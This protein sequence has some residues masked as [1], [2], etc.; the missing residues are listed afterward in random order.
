ML[1]RVLPLWSNLVQQLE[2]FVLEIQI[3]T[4]TL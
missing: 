3:A 4:G 2:R 1:V